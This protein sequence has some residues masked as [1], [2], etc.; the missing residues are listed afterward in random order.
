MTVGPDVFFE[1]VDV[2]YG[3]VKGRILFHA[4]DFVNLEA[5]FVEQHL[6]DLDCS[7]ISGWVSREAAWPEDW[8]YSQLP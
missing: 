7:G 5:V 2:A 3:F 8:R 1:R 6:D 4:V